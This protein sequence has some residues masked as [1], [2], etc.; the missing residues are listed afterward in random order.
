M[1]RRVSGVAV[2]GWSTDIFGLLFSHDADPTIAVVL[3]AM[4]SSV[5]TSL[6][7]LPSPLRQGVAARLSSPWFRVAGFFLQILGFR[8]ARSFEDSHPHLLEPFFQRIVLFDLSYF[9]VQ[10]PQI[11]AERNEQCCAARA[12]ERR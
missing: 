3:E 1:L 2:A 8:L 5:S 11:A 10:H 9:T 12:A 7:P 6:P 4:T